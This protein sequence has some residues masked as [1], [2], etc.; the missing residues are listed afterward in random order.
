MIF[1]I[2]GDIALVIHFLWIVFLTVG[3]PFILYLN[4]RSIRIFHVWALV[5]T[6]GMQLFGMYCPLTYVEEYLKRRQDPSFSYGGSFIISQLE[7]MVYVEV[8][9]HIIATLTAFF[10]LAVILSFWVRPLSKK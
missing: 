4:I 6:L 8:S 9:P 1:G 10:L 2:L 3:F 5:A 7:K